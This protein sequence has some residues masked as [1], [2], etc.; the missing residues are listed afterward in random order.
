MKKQVTL[1]DIDEAFLNADTHNSGTI[2]KEEMSAWLV[3][4]MKNHNNYKR[5]NKEH[6]LKIMRE[7]L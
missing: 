4:F 5:E 6:I 7:N 1:G 3:N 2:V